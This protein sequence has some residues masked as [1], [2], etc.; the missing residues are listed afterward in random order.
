MD[1]L[2]ELQVFVAI[3]DA[4]SLSRAGRR[5]GKSPAAVTR[6]LANLEAR[7]GQRLVER[8]T[9]KLAATEAGRRLADQARRML[10]DYAAAIAPE[11]AGGPLRGRLAITA[12]LVFGRRH[13]TCI[14]TS[15]LDQNPQISAEL[16]LSD[17]NL[18]LIDDHLDVAVRIGP[19]A[20]S[21]LVAR[22]VGEVRSLTVASPDYVARMG[23]PKTPQGLERH[24]TLLTTSRGRAPDWRYKG[25]DGR[26]LT[27]RVAPRL[28]ISDVDATLQAVRDGH[29]IA[30][31]LSYQVVEDLAAGRLVRLLRDFEPEPLPVQLVTQ[32]LRLIPARV[33]AFL[34]HAAVAIGALEV[35]QP[36]AR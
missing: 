25:P 32:S 22:R 8:T 7:A 35:V 10:A 15:F 13:V 31:A 33:R 20:D 36:D 24:Q 28:T 3:L 21:S 6:S 23:A 11:S 1:R 9:R 16:L 26:D 5:L 30:R 34:D 18:D 19:L 4:G 29:G 27:V 12:P 2:D 14:L 17:R